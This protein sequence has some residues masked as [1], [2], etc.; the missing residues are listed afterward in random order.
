MSAQDLDALRSMYEAFNR[1]DLAALL[2]TMHP[3]VEASSPDDLEFAALML[4]LLGPRFVV[5]LGTSYRGKEEVR[6]LF[7]AMW[8]ISERLVVEPQEYV[9]LDEGVVA[10]IILRARSLDAGIES[11]V[12]IAHAWTF[13][14]AKLATLRA[15]ADRERA[16]SALR[17]TGK[18]EGE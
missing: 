16:V 13:S 18:R 3:D 5:L 17:Q 9:E 14:E 4:R 1:R 11:E 2:E 8:A 6:R 10:P 15:F 7:E 12:H